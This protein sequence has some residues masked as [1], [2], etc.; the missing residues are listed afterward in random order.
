MP[1]KRRAR[2]FATAPVV[3]L[4]KNGSSTTSPGSV[5]ESSARATSASG[6]WVG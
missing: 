1:M 6:F 3:P 4:P 5:Q 2:R